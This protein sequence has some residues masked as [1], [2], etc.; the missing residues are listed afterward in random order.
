MK[1]MKIDINKIIALELRNKHGKRF[2]N[3]RI[4]FIADYLRIDF[5]FLLELNEKYKKVWYISLDGKTR[6]VY[7]IDA[8]TIG[9]NYVFEPFDLTDS[10]KETI[11]SMK[12]VDVPNTPQ[13]K[14]NKV[15][16]TNEVSNIFIEDLIGDI[17][18]DVDTILDKI[19]AT[20]MKSLS[21]REL[22]FLNGLSK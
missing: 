10:D 1:S 19:S 22:E 7:A 17:D 14:K 13:G 9:A 8:T 5:D 2:S 15:S 16:K 4:Q 18:L 3:T 20:G 6:L 11:K 12:S 21:K